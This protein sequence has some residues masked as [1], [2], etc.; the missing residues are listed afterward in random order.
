MKHTLIVFILL[1]SALSFGQAKINYNLID[2]KMHAIPSSFANST[3]SIA[4][5]I[6]TNFKTDNDKIRAVFF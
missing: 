6:K 5:Y 2:N 1:I 3:D 4:K